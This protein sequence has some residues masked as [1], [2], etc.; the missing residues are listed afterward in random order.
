MTFHDIINGMSTK[1]KFS[2]K[3]DSETL[4]KL[5]KHAEES[6]QT[7]STIVSEAVAEYLSRSRLRP[8]FM[9][10]AQRVIEDN[11]ELLERLAK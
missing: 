7:I 5:R 10:E 9:S 1:V 4:V 2:S 8:K 11:R 3:I 6:N